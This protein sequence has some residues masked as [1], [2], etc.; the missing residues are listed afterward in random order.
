MT[1]NARHPGTPPALL[2]LSCRPP[3]QE[4]APG[5]RVVTSMVGRVATSMGV[6][7]S[8]QVVCSIKGGNE[9]IVGIF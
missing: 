1:N 6:A 3:W 9:K 2:H 7:R 8:P 5:W 4:K